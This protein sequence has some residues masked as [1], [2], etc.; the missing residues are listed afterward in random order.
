[1][2]RSLHTELEMEKQLSLLFAFFFFVLLVNN[3]KGLVSIVDNSSLGSPMGYTL[4]Q[5]ENEVISL[6]SKRKRVMHWSEWRY[7]ELTV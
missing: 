5:D 1:M 6:H 2:V 3:R 4:S 7:S